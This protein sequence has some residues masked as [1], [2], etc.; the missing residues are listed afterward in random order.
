[1]TELKAFQQ[2]APVRVWADLK[3]GLEWKLTFMLEDAMGSALDSLV[4]GKWPSWQRGDELWKTTCLEAFWGVPDQT[5]Y[6][7]LNLSPSQQLWNLY[8]FEDYRKPQP[9]QRSEDFELK[10][11]SAT[12]EK[13]TCV[14]IPKVTLPKVEASLS[15]IVRGSQNTHYFALKHAGTKADFHLRASF[16]F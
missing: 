10:D 7:E 2:P 9:P 13:L 1:V 14:L 12:L 4:P 11:I 8:H 16:T 5:A 3:T 6:W 15:A